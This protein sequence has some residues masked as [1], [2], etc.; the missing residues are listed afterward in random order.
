MK[1]IFKNIRAKLRRIT[2]AKKKALKDINQSELKKVEK[3]VF[4]INRF[5]GNLFI[6]WKKIKIL[7]KK[8]NK[9]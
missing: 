5:F 8:L 3:E 6:S 4:G 7:E 9:K 1:F 2:F